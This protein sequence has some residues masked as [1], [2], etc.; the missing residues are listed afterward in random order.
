VQSF[1]YAILRI[2]PRVE[3]E[4]FVNVGVIVYCKDQHFLKV[5]IS[6]DEKKLQALSHDIDLPEITSHLESFRQIA[7]GSGSGPIAQLDM[8]SRFR[9]LTATRSTVLQ[10]SKVHPGKC[11]DPADKLNRLFEE[12][13]VS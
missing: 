9:W 10:T 7:D 5:K 12:Y 3:R 1:E 13:V 6:I 4:E 8:G 2:V 11:I